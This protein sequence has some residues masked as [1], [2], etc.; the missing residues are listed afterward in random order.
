MLALA[1]VL[2]IYHDIYETTKKLKSHGLL[3]KKVPVEVHS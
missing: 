2:Q 3:P 1:G